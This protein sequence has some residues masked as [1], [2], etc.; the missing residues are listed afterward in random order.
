MKAAMARALSSKA[1][2][3]REVDGD[4]DGNGSSSSG[5]EE[6]IIGEPLRDQLKSSRGSRLTLLANELR[7]VDKILRP[8]LSRDGIVNGFMDCYRWSIVHPDARLM[9][10]KN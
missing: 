10:D 1:M 3:R 2:S 7:L 4:E 6:F 5:E 9:D 8:K